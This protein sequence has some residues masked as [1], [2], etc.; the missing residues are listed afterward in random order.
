MTHLVPKGLDK[1]T[2]AIPKY[3]VDQYPTEIHLLQQVA[4]WVL[5]NGITAKEL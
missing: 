2:C 5:V 4:Y 1:G 3:V